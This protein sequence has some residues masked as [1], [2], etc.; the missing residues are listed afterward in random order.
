MM[1]KGALAQAQ[2]KEQARVTLYRTLKTIVRMLDARGYEIVMMGFTEVCSPSQVWE[3]LEQYKSPERI[4]AAE[5]SHEIILEAAVKQT[6]RKFTTAWAQATP[7]EH[8]LIVICIDQGNVETMR[9]VD[10][11][12]K[13]IEVQSAIL[14]SRR[15]LTAYSK[16]FLADGSNTR[17]SIQHFQYAELQA[18]IIDHSMVPRH[19]PLTAALQ[20]RVQ[21]KYRGGKFPRLL[22]SDPMVRFLGLTLGSM[23]A[24][25]EVYGREQAVLT[26]FEVCEA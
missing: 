6:T 13:Q 14:I 10:D 2:E 9:E 19:L 16:K 26:Y 20:A 11:A 1:P 17:G 25:R 3:E 7:L 4:L 8:K 5:T 12:M 23:V 21:A 24:I 18:S 22:L 15:D